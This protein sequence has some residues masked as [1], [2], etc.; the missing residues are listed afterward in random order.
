MNWR[1]DSGSLIWRPA[2]ASEVVWERDREEGVA[3]VARAM[4]YSMAQWVSSEHL[5]A[6]PFA[7][8][9]WHHSALGVGPVPNRPELVGPVV[10]PGL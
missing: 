8:D 10:N 2:V 4:V 1:A 6:T 5:Y 7:E 3:S 9:W